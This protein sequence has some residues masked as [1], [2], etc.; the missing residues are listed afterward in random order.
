MRIT[1][2]N[3]H[4][5]FRPWRPADG[6]VFHDAFAIDTETTLI[7]PERPW[8]VP[9]YVLG[10]ACDGN[11]GVFLT[12]EHLPAFLRAHDGV[13]LVFH[14]APFDLAVIHQL[15]PQLDIYRHVERGDVWDTQLLH[16]L[17]TLATVGHTAQGKGGATLET[18]AAEYLGVALPKDDC[19]SH[20]NLVRLSFAQFLHRPPSDIE[21]VYLEYVAQDTLATYLVYIELQQRIAELL[22]DSGA[23]WGFVSD[24]W[25]A[26]QIQNFGPL[27][28]H[29]QLRGAIV[30]REI[31]AAGL[32]IH[33]EHRAELI[34]QLER[35]REEHRS[36]L[37]KLGYLP[38]QPGSGK[39]LQEILRGLAAK[40]PTVFFPRT[41]NRGDYATS[42]EALYALKGVEPFIDSLLAFRA[43][44]KLLSTFL[45]KIGRA[46][47]HASFDALVRTGRT[48]SFGE[49]NAQNLPRDDRVRACFV[50]APGHVFINADYATI[51]LATLA[52]SVERQLGLRSQMAAAINAG[53]DLHRLVA[54]R[55]F[56]KPEDAVTKG[57]RQKAKAINFGKPGGM[58]ARALQQYAATSYGVL[59]SDAEVAALA[60]SW[61]DLFPEM[62]EFLRDEEGVVTSLAASLELTPTTYYDYTDRDTFLRHPDNAGRAHT[63]HPILGAMLLKV[64]KEAEPHTSS[65]R[66]YTSAELDY[67]WSRLAEHI[68]RLPA[69]CH[70][71]LRHRRPSATLQRTILREFGRRSVFTWTGRLRAQAT[72][73]ARHNTMFQGLAADGAKLALWQLW[74]AGFRIVNFIHDEVMV[75]VPEQAN[76]A[77][78]A[79]LVRHLM[80]EAM[81]VVVPDVAVDVEYAVSRRWAKSAE[82]VVDEQGRLAVWQPP[83]LR[84]PGQ[85][86][87]TTIMAV[88]A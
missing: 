53:R 1:L 41:A 85:T 84:V 56:G 12:R 20:G 24:R 45:K 19:D 13:P 37:R 44:D 39:A 72:F 67:F 54:A 46:R 2:A 27:T 28:H 17:Y 83:E 87:E 38:G 7:D 88:P 80:I 23:V 34:Q 33:T 5:D 57:E 35:V 36:E 79:E 49:L 21:P 81:R 47:I 9:T 51:E 66:S 18:C 76:L 16:R 11:R 29:I 82:A 15:V 52:Q 26:T 4:V 68:D 8:L 14:N 31:T 75:E 71:D 77:L 61:L 63:P 3:Q 62:R 78:Q 50:P 22:A 86:I 65:G 69:S 6:P 42:E 60:E 58:G 73:A 48:S 25:L 74:R 30:L 70:A 64:V 59:L 10:A 40:H 32:G 43:V 55:F